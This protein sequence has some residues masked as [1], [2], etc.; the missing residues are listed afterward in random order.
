MEKETGLFKTPEGLFRISETP[1]G[2]IKSE[3]F[4]PGKGFEPGGNVATIDWE[5]REVSEEEA[6]GLMADTSWMI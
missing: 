2:G 4:V 1:D 5:G 3:V 6:K